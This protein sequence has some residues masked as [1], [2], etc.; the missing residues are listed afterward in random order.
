MDGLYGSDNKYDS[1]YGGGRGRGGGYRGGRGGRGG[2][3]YRGRG[4]GGYHNDRPVDNGPDHS[5]KC[6][7][8]MFLK[9]IIHCR[10]LVGPDDQVAVKIRGLPYQTRYEEISDFFGDYQYIER[11]VILGLNN[12]GRKNGFGA[13]LFENEDE[14]QSAAK[15]MDGQHV[16][17]RYVD[18]SVISYG[19]Y[20]RFNKPND[21][22]GNR[23]N[24]KPVKLSNYVDQD[25]QARALVM[26]G[27]PYRATSQ[28]VQ[29]FF[30][31]FGSL[32]EGDIF[33]EEFNG[34][35]TGSALVV[36]ENEAVAQDAK[37]ALHRKEIEGRY[38]ELFDQHDAFMQKICYLEAPTEGN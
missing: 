24:T 14:A 33:I 32:Q 37:S 31:G 22:G 28:I 16:G 15:G 18:L 38:I 7:F 12:E 26:R 21:F 13:I 27:L 19:D 1:G 23:P 35:R 30:D 3:G 29:E 10:V 34:R 4:G 8:S 20:K 25:N 17:S 5:D 36:F 6:K 11:S 2:G 9:L